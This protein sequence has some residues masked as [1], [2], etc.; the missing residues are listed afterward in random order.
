MK[1][2]YK[3]L[4]AGSLMLSTSGLFAQDQRSRTIDSLESVLKYATERSKEKIDLMNELSK[5]YKLT[6]PN[7]ALEY[8]KAALSLAEN[9]NYKNGMAFGLSYTGQIYNKKGEYEK[10]INNF[11]Q[12]L[13]LFEELGNNKQ[14]A[15]R[16]NDIAVIHWNQG[17]YETSLENVFKSLNLHDEI[18]N[19]KGVAYCYNGIGVLKGE[20]GKHKEGL[21][22]LEKSLEIYKQIDDKAGIADDLHNMGEFQIQLNEFEKAIEYLNQ[23]LKLSEELSDQQSISDCLNNLGVVYSKQGKYEEAITHSRSSLAIAKE[24]G[25]KKDIMLAYSN[26]SETYAKQ[27]KFE[28]AYEYYHMY[29]EMKDKLYYSNQVSKI[30]A[31]FDKEKREHQMEIWKKE[32]ELEEYRATVAKYIAVGLVLFL[33]AV[34]FILY[35]RYRQKKKIN[36]ELEVKNEII[37]E[38]NREITDSINYAQRIQQAILPS[39]EFITKNLPDSF[40]YYK[41]RDIVSGDFY[42]MTKV[43]DI[44]IFAVVDCT[45]HGVPGAFMSMIGNENLIQIVTDRMV[46]SPSHALSLLDKRVSNTFK[47][48]DEQSIKNK[49]GMDMALCAFHK[50]T[51][52]V[53]FAGAR[54]PLWVVRNGE[55]I[56]YKA[57]KLSIG[58]TETGDKIFEDH[59]IQLEKG[60][61]IYLFSD[62]YPDQ[63]GGPKGKKYMLKKFKELILSIAEK[64]MKVQSHILE[65]E[66]NNWKGQHQQVD[67]ILVM[68]I[69]V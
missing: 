36:K 64:P 40:V 52:K 32:K 38:K 29:A 69:K 4:F 39:N 50:R 9:T 63:F 5:E 42:W 10:A 60:D 12:A 26:L 68:G 55:I 22:Y 30:E 46:T 19:K 59:A 58:G 8:G 17:D 16:Y 48:Q 2:L 21:V 43:D 20:Q 23:A 51:K 18:G 49:D 57:T 27:H 44:V 65:Q 25:A 35:R 3:Y 24:I 11:L 67:D 13:E 37:E 14:M 6:N 56:E 33:G 15:F 28:Y 31:K 61:V 54:R 53:Q 41:P 62:G 66:F 47:S 1:L 45:G 7:K 34:L